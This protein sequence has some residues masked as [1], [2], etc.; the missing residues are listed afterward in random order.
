VVVLD[1]ERL[2]SGGW[3]PRIGL[4]DPPDRT[5]LVTAGLDVEIAPAD[6]TG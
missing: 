3:T 2:P 5:L 6:V 4:R 1:P